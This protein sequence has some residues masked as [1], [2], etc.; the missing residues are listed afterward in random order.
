MPGGPRTHAQVREGRQR[1]AL[2]KRSRPHLRLI[3]S[4]DDA[5]VARP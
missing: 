1:A 4:R 5:Q 2:A 3:Y